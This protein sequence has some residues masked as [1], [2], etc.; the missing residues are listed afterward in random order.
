M[1]VYRW[2]T[3]EAA[4]AYDA[5]AEYIHPCYVEIQDQILHLLCQR[6]DDAP[7]VVDA[8]GGSGR[9]MER[10][11]EQLPHAEGVLFDQSEPYLALS[12]ERLS[13][14]GSRA[15]LVQHRLQDDWGQALPRPA[16]AIVSM[17]AIHH[18][19]PREKQALFARSRENLVPGGAFINGD[20]IRQDSEDTYLAE[21]KRWAQHMQ[22]GLAAG[23]I[24]TAFSEMVSNWKR[25]NIDQF[26]GVK[27]SGDDYHETVEVQLDYLR[28][29]GFAD[30]KITWQ[31]KM[32]A[33]FVA[34]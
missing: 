32:W 5:A 19:D 6:S 8:G 23:R 1:T 18:L 33:I 12:A 27:Q 29:A 26:G 15:T 9:L 20:E 3:N 11:L 21:L 16:S 25:R 31:Q 30:A 13:R 34:N 10:I 22:Q 24:P 17:S 7:L 14:F 4:R 28:A 2:N